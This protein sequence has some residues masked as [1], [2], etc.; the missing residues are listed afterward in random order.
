MR[1]HPGPVRLRS[2]ESRNP[3]T[4]HRIL[5]AAADELACNGIT[6]FNIA[7]VADRAQVSRSTTYSYFPS[8][9]HLLLQ[10]LRQSLDETTNRWTEND[11][12]C[13]RVHATSRALVNAL[14]GTTGRRRGAVSALVSPDKRLRELQTGIGEELVDRF[15]T[16]LGERARADVVYTLVLATCGVLIRA[17]TGTIAD[18]EIHEQLDSSIKVIL[19]GVA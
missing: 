10:V 5:D 13:Q 19:K 16:A 11:D 18:R 14:A 1:E 2:L 6:N 12:V 4:T 7:A 3:E 15:A 17:G 8:R 9:N